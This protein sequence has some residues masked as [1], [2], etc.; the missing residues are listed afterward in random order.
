MPISKSEAERPE[1]QIQCS[2]FT[3]LSGSRVSVEPTNVGQ[4]VPWT[5]GRG[6]G[7]CI[8]RRLYAPPITR[9]FLDNASRLT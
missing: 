4:D 2:V 5:R 7:L 9:P 3:L 8:Y 1:K 6:R